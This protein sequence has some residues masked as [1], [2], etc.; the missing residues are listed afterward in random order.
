MTQPT[1]INKTPATAPAAAQA[2]KLKDFLQQA[3]FGKVL[4][5]FMAKKADAFIRLAMVDIP[6]N[7]QLARIAANS[8][9][10]VVA[11]LMDCARLGLMPGPMGHVYLVPFGNEIQVITGYKGLVEL[12]RRSGEVARVDA[13]VIY[14]EDAYTYVKGDSP[15]FEHLPNLASSKR[16]HGDIIAAYAF[17]YD[18][19]GMNLGGAVM[20]RAEIDA[21]RG[22]SKTGSSGP[23]KTDYAE[24][25]KKTA[26]RRASKLWPISTEFVE[27][28]T[29]DDTHED[30]IPSVVGSSSGALENRPP[31][32]SSD[33]Y[34]DDAE[35]LPTHTD[36][37][38]PVDPT[39]GEV[40]YYTQPPR[41]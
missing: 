7:P 14:A 10:K 11:A 18:A 1:N 31:M 22:R 41:S 33:L 32:V 6:R 5:E 38:E 24:M 12:A 27:A 35:A 29:L 8:P 39:T 28:V 2:P 17:A 25:A 26:L 13:D 34:A 23:W 36:D 9:K 20:A 37:G 4:P 16:G 21:I 40:G 30:R 19:N 3:N 15:K